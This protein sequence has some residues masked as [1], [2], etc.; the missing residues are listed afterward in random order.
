[1]KKAQKYYCTECG[2]LYIYLE[3]IGD[4][5]TF[6]CCQKG[7]CRHVYSKGECIGHL[8]DKIRNIEKQIEKLKFNQYEPYSD[9]VRRKENKDA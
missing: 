2:E 8:R 5:V 9:V 6:Y 3:D 7:P 4:N 1:M